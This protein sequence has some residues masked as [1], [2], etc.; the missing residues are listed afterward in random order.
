MPETKT[1]KTFMENNY[2]IVKSGKK[3]QETQKLVKK[4]TVAVIGVRWQNWLCVAKKTAKM[5]KKTV[6]KVARM[7]KKQHDR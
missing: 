2:R 6:Y 3:L 1:E 4:K 7:A 5:A